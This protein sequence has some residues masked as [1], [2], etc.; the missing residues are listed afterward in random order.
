VHLD[1]LAIV[2]AAPGMVHVVQGERAVGW[3]LKM[4]L[5]RPLSEFL[6]EV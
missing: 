4:P 3:H 1:A 6:G 2:A 5:G